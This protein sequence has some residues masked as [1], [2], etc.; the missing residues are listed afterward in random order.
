VA[1][2]ERG[3][4]VKPATALFIIL[5]AA[6]QARADDGGVAIGD[7][8]WSGRLG[9]GVDTRDSRMEIKSSTHHEA[10]FLVSGV[11]LSP[12][13][14]IS[15]YGPVGI[16]VKPLADLDIGGSG[17]GGSTS[18]LLLNGAWGEDMPRRQISL[19]A[20]GSDRFQHAIRSVHSTRPGANHLDLMYWEPGVGDMTRPARVTA[21]SF[22]ARNA[23][24]GVHV[25]P[26]GHA[27]VELAISNGR[28]AEGGI[29]HRR[30][31]AAPMAFENMAQVRYLTKMDY[32]NAY[33]AISYLRH[34]PDSTGRKLLVAGTAPTT[35]RHPNMNSLDERLAEVEM[36]AR[37]LIQRLERLDRALAGTG[38]AP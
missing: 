32:A 16:G 23:G 18:L 14:S 15:T 8:F 33:D 5:L 29:M 9:I 36:A 37:E 11:D 26:V 34:V 21:L 31:E 4:S 3:T 1:E 13:L 27:D 19:G 20:Y 6:S 22:R 28:E 10:A 25:L 2:A 38:G 24:G 30:Y 12:F 17:W 35:R 7:I